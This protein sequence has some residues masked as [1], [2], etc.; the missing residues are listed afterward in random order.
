MRCRPRHSVNPGRAGRDC[1]ASRRPVVT[2]WDAIPG[3]VARP[4]VSR[5]AIGTEDV[6]CVLNTIEPEMQ[7]APHVHEGFDQLAF[8]LKGRAVYHIGDQGHPVGPG[9]CMVIPA[10]MR[11]W[12]EPDGDE[13][14]ENLD[15]FAPAREDYAHL[16]GWMGEPDAPGRA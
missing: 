4:G 16:L 1:V 11:H 15:V 6:M 13:P 3:E 2:T 7:P 10:G 5:R 12:L 14:I 9:A 8:I